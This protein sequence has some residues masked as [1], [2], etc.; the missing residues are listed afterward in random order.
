M[1]RV[2]SVLLAVLMLLSVAPVSAFAEGDVVWNYPTFV[3]GSREVAPG[4]II[5]V[6]VSIENNPGIVSFIWQINY[7]DYAM[8][9]LK[10]TP[11]QYTSIVV[12]SMEDNPITFIWHEDTLKQECFDEGEVLL[13]TFRIK[14]DAA[15]GE[16]PLSL[17]YD[18]A[19][20]FN[21]AFESVRFNVHNGWIT[22]QSTECNHEYDYPCAAECYLCGAI[23]E[24]EHAW[25][26]IS[27]TEPTCSSNG[28]YRYRCDLCGEPYMEATPATGEH[29][30]DDDADPD[31]NYCGE[32]REVE[33][34]PHKYTVKVLM[35]ATCA[36]GGLKRYTCVMCGDSYEEST[37]STGEHEYDNDA[38]PDCNNCGE[39][40]EVE[41]H[42]HE[43]MEKGSQQP[44]C[45][46]DGW[47]KLY[48]PGCGVMTRETI[49]AFG[50]AYDDDFDAD[51]NNCGEKRDV[52]ECPHKYTVKVLMAATCAKGGLKRYT[53]VMCGDSYE[54]STPSTGEHEYDNDADPDC[55]N[56]GEKRDVEVHV[57]EWMEKDSQ[58][59]TCTTDGWTRLYCPGCGET[60]RETIPAFGHSYDNDCDA[61]CNNCGE[62]REVG[63][64]AY[65]LMPQMVKP[66]CTEAGRYFYYCKICDDRY[67]EDIPALGH[68][69]DDDA[70]PDCNNCGEIREV[71][72]DVV[73]G[74]CQHAYK[75]PEAPVCAF[76]GEALSL[77][78]K[79]TVY[80]VADNAALTRGDEFTL[81]V[82][83][84]N[85]PGLVA[86]RVFVGYD[87]NV[88][89]PVAQT[90]G[91]LFPAKGV[92]FG[93]LGKSPANAMFADTIAEEDYEGDGVLFTLTFRVKED[94]AIGTSLL[95]VYLKTAADFYDLAWSNFEVD[96]LGA[97]VVVDDHVHAYDGICDGE[98]NICGF[99][100]DAAEHAY[101]NAC[102]AEC[103]GCGLVREVKPHTYTV[104]VVDPTCEGEGVK[105]SVCSICGDTVTETIPALGH[106]YTV[107]VFD[108]DCVN[109]GYTLHS[110]NR[111]RYSYTD[112]V[113]PALGH[114]PG[115]PADCL[116]SQ[117]C[118]ACGV[119]LTPALGHAYEAEVTAPTCEADGYTTHTCA[120]CGDNY[121]DSTVAALGHAYEAVV[122]AP[123]C[124]ADGYTTH[125]C[126]RCG[127]SYKDSTVAAL[128]H[129]HDNACDAECNACG[130]I[131]EVPDHV[132]DHKY[133]ATCNECGDVREIPFIPGDVNN[134]TEINV[135]DLGLLQQYLNE[136]EV[137]INEL[138]ADV[139]YDNQI[140]VRDYGLLQ[141]YLNDYDVNLGA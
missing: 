91:T 71:E 83:L 109:D 114:K 74:E 60:T 56:C 85:N 141:Q 75:N 134:D 22:V 80:G 89:E 73:V 125:T 14:E 21:G 6:P 118:T 58:Q 47:T 24:V 3:V 45:T 49:P 52:E 31:C 127:D 36:K 11:L 20:V 57:H 15:A 34:C 61:S 28:V 53:C 136:Y 135:R 44:T 65:A 137:T 86:W 97:T 130:A 113:V 13:L 26:L 67:N 40:R 112:A 23:R 38:D 1:K 17:Y 10:V 12:N 19:N 37:P 93:K 64:H 126:A 43:W 111:C 25:V 120:R 51:C 46:T 138:A 41:V 103:N 82:M 33:E 16:Y 123:T 35:A 108:P 78:D 90:R 106:D 70:D 9:L 99:T 95:D 69:Y 84:K 72:G 98:C 2:L 81:S 50:H 62:S 128:G 140:N 7:E 100:R 32:K 107:T 121:K 87:V 5:D 29:A 110:C 94:A 54:E 117:T 119:E 79:I 92:T 27:A 30:Y 116:N 105:T 59:P 124:E 8:E 133:D 101:D 88:L 18:P 66:T 115:A 132:Y 76:C 42:V 77:S 139:F 4:D 39:K 48:C 129:R 131:R 96:T 55:N 68:A 63:E 122:T 102:D 104:K